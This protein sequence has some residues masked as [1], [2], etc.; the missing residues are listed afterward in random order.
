MVRYMNQMPTGP[1]ACTAVL[2]LPGVVVATVYVSCCLALII[3]ITQ[4]SRLARRRDIPVPVAASLAGG[5]LIYLSLVI[6]GALG[7]LSL[8]PVA[9]S[10]VALSV[11]AIYVTSRRSTPNTPHGPH[12]SVEDTATNVR[13]APWVLA[14]GLG[15]LGMSPL[16]YFASAMP[17]LVLTRSWPLAW[18]TV[19]YHIPAFIDFLQACSLWRVA[20]PF[21]S[22]SFAF[23]LIGGFPAV[24]YPA[25]WG[26]VVAHAYSVVLLIAAILL[27]VRKVGAILD[28]GHESH[29]LLAAVIAIG[30]WSALF[31]AQLWDI[32]K[33]DFFAAGC[34]LAMFGLLLE[35]DSSAE[36]TVA[37]RG[38]LV[39][40]ASG[41]MALA[42]AAKPTSLAYIPLYAALLFFRLRASATSVR[43]SA[44]TIL[45]LAA[46]MTVGGFFYARNLS[47]FGSITDPRL[48]PIAVE[49]SILGNLRDSRLYRLNA[50][51]AVFLVAAGSIVPLAFLGLRAQVR[52]RWSAFFLVIF[53][54]TG[55]GALMMTPWLINDL[56][57]GAWDLRLAMPFFTMA[58][59]VYGV[60]VARR[61]HGIPS[62]RYPLAALGRLLILFAVLFLPWWWTHHPPRGLPGFEQQRGLPSTGIYRWV[63]GLSGHFRIY[64]MGVFPYGLYGSRWE[65]RVLYDLSSKALE[66]SGQAGEEKL[67]AVIDSFHPDLVVVG[68]DPFRAEI[69]FKKPFVGWLRA[70]PRLI[71]VYCDAV[72]SAFAISDGAAARLPQQFSSCDL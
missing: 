41:A 34:I 27:A 53:Y 65:N 44:Q 26:F 3:A 62:G 35:A 58:A 45:L 18:D 40:L 15:V 61:V 14:L 8:V 55:L 51:T 57:D 39:V 48:V 33:N 59:V 32:G 24:F 5:A 63:Q 49:T 50:D 10:I 69:S 11:V 67:A 29:Q 25:H 7:M 4:V 21:Q 28:E 36:T 17:F 47:I 46:V 52:R 66:S 6:P 42:V 13:H 23:E 20:A 70:Q 60:A 2:A 71:E 38:A 22:Y 54:G 37:P 30:A 31:R 43:A 19:S 72:V 12:I 64:S 16:L 1:G 9:V 56:D 68:I